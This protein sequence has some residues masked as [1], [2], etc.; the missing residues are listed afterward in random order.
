MIKKLMSKTKDS[1]R[2]ENQTEP[3]QED[4]EDLADL[5]KQQEKTPT[6]RSF[7]WK[8]ILL[9]T[10]AGMLGFVFISLISI[11]LW[12]RAQ[13]GELY[14]D[15]NDLPEDY[16]IA[17]VFGAG[18]RANQFP[19]AVLDHRLQA[20]VEL[21]QAGKVEKILMSG[22][23]R[24]VDY[25]EPLVMTNYAIRLGVP[26]EDIIQDYAGRRTYDTCYRANAIFGLESAILVTQEFHLR[27]ASYTCDYLG[28]ENVGFIA[29]QG[30]YQEITQWRIRETI[31]VWVN[32][33]Q[34]HITKP[35]PVLGEEEPIKF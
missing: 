13:A 31:A 22:D 2:V 11:W 33:G 20:A 12:V 1:V 15:V 9:W 10:S 30:S 3:I 26:E 25:N 24:A 34:L 27:R 35:E 28:V 18:V 8:K 14:D 32:W 16:Q 17:I 4:Q 5:N 23:N 7:F 29:D 21:Y 6:S 19:S